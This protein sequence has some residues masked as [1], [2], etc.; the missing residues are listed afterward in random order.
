METLTEDQIERRVSLAIDKLD[1]RLMRNE[2]TQEQYD[3]EVGI[4]DSWA[5]QQYKAA[6]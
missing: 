4:V 1:R 2:L 6:P 3:H 5:N